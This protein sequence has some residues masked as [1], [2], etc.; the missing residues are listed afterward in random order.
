MQIS[1]NFVSHALNKHEEDI[2]E[3]CYA[4]PPL[5]KIKLSV[6]DRI[7]ID[8]CDCPFSPYARSCNAGR[9]FYHRS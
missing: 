5:S 8:D 2:N 6:S 4:Q 9:H 7:K 3:P 1:I